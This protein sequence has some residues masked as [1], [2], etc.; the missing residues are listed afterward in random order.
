MAIPR[1]MAQEYTCLRR[2]LEATGLVHFTL[3]SVV[4]AEL[5]RS[6]G[7]GSSQALA[8]IIFLQL[9]NDGNLTVQRLSQ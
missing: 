1:M 8:G 9:A 3:L 5:E 4:L 6:L 2:G 7:S